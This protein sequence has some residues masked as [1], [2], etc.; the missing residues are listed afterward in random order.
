MKT[1]AEIFYDAI[2][3]DNDL[4]TAIGGRVVSTCFEIPPDELDNTPLPNIIITNDGFQNNFDTK[5]D[6][7]ESNVDS[8]QAS[9]D[10]A[11]SSPHEVD[12]LVSKIRKAIQTYIMDMYEDGEEIPELQPGF[13]SS[14][15]IEWDWVKPCYHQNVTYQCIIQKTDDDEQD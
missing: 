6:I 2:S 5:D 14:Q 3:A 11:A 8:V 12:E 15:G 7:W 13:P 1:L 9:V 4:M 10:V